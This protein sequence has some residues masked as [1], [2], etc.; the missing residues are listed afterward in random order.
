M[1]ESLIVKTV[2]EVFDMKAGAEPFRSA[3]WSAFGE[4]SRRVVDWAVKL[5]MDGVT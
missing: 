3:C 5:V 4:P 2:S 1:P